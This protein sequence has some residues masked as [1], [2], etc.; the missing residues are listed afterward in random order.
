VGQVDQDAIFYLCSR[1]IPLAEARSLLTYAF[2]S[3]ILEKIQ[4]ESLRSRL[5]RALSE[6]LKGATE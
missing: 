5:S 4:V 3:D 2:A 6:W 1:G